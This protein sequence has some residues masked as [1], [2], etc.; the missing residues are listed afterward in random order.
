MNRCWSNPRLWRLGF[1]DCG[2]VVAAIGMSSAMSPGFNC[3]EISP[4]NLFAAQ[5]N[6]LGREGEYDWEKLSYCGGRVVGGLATD[7]G[8]QADGRRA[9]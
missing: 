8:R 7:C 3:G 9:G 4:P 5:P 2:V 6:A 1:D